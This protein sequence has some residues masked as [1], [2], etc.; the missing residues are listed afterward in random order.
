MPL[1]IVLPGED[2]QVVA[3]PAHEAPWRCVVWDD[4]VNLM[5]YVTYVFMSHFG[6]RRERA[7]TLMLRV[8]EAGSAIVSTGG[9]ERIEADVQAMH[10][11][12]LWATMAQE[13]ER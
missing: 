10:R 6:Y 12:G 1:P 7:Q 2:P 8:H 3:R 11:Y 5:S 9:R 4:P 13:G